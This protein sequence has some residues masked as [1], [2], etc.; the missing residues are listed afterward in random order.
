MEDTYVLGCLRK[1]RKDGSEVRSKPCFETELWNVRENLLS[2]MPRT[3]N[4]LEGWH[5]RWRIL[6]KS[7][8]G[9]Y[10]TICN[11]QKEQQI[12]NGEILKILQGIPPTKRNAKEIEKDRRLKEVAV[13]FDNYESLNDYLLGIALVLK[14]N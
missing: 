3:T 9:F 7:N 10:E 5:N 2:D 6:N 4:R 1:I 14:D 13:N 12:T 11:F 8:G